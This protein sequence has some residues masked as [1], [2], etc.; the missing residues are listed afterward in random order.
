MPEELPIQK[1]P[2]TPHLA[3]FRLQSGDEAPG[4]I[5]FSRH[6]WAAHRGGGKVRWRQQRGGL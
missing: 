3:G 1:C 5:L 2:R 4:Q 6:C